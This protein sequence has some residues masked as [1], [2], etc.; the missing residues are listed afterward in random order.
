[1]EITVH[2]H[3]H[4]DPELAGLLREV[5]HFLKGPIMS[6]LTDLQAAVAAEDTVI[7][8]A[9]TLLN[10]IA[11]QLKDAIAANDPAALQA[12]HDKLTA[13]TN[14]LAAAVAANTSPTP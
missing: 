5:L 2:L 9:I 11:A 4:D 12:V 6:A 13:E 14:S 8:S 3:R 7:D 1:M 10:G